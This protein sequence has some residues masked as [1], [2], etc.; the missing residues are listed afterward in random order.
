MEDPPDRVV[1]VE[2]STRLEDT[3]ELQRIRHSR[4]RGSLQ[5]ADRLLLTHPGIRTRGDQDGRPPGRQ[6]RGGARTARAAQD[7]DDIEL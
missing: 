2:A 7:V 4:V 3:H 1:T 5:V 6:P